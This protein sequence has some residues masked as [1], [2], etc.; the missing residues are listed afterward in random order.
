[1]CAQKETLGNR[2]PGQDNLNKGARQRA[3]GTNLV[4]EVKI[5]LRAKWLRGKLLA[6]NLPQQQEPMGVAQW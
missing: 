6:Y 3:D 4:K 5:K 1:M 2:E